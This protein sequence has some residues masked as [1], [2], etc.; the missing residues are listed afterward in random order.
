MILSIRQYFIITQLIFVHARANQMCT[1]GEL[2]FYLMLEMFQARNKLSMEC[3]SC[4]SLL[5][6]SL[7]A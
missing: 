4:D 2:D 6:N 1:S 3:M 7:G 5:V